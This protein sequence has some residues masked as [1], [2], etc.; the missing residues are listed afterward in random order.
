MILCMI[1][2]LIVVVMSLNNWFLK[3]KL[4]IAEFDNSWRP[5]LDAVQSKEELLPFYPAIKRSVVGA[6]KYAEKVP[7][8]I[9]KV[10]QEQ[11]PA[12]QAEKAKAQPEE[13]H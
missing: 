7:A 4:E 13:H 12:Q 10:H 5:T 3:A 11:E 8:S 6:E 9:P 2:C 1:L